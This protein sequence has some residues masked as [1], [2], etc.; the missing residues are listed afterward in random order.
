MH[1]SNGNAEYLAFSTIFCR[2]KCPANSEHSIPIY[3]SDIGKYELCSADHRCATCIP[4][5]FFKLNK[6]QMKQGFFGS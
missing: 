6:I 5:L 2:N 3:Y 4:N 1:F